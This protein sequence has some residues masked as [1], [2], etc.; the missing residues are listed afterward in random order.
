MTGEQAFVQVQE[1]EPGIERHQVVQH[2]RAAAPVPEYEDW[3]FGNGSAGDASAVDQVFDAVHQAVVAGYAAGRQQ[4]VE[5]TDGDLGFQAEEF[6]ETPKG[7][8]V[9]Q[10]DA[11]AW[12]QVGDCFDARIP[13]LPAEGG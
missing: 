6:A 7:Q 1:S 4:A 9:P 3:G 5:V 11:V 10:T 12:W 2:G 13:V 8:A